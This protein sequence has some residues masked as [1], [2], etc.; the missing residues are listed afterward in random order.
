M[1]HINYTHRNKTLHN[2]CMERT[3]WS[4]LETNKIVKINGG[5]ETQMYQKWLVVSLG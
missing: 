3:M 1:T 5:Q 2:N 4:S